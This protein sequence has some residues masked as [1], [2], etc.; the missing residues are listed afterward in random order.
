MGIHPA[1]FRNRAFKESASQKNWALTVFCAHLKSCRH[2]ALLKSGLIQRLPIDSEYAVFFART[3]LLN[4]LQRAAGES[5]QTPLHR[6]QK[7]RPD[8]ESATSRRKSCCPDVG[9]AAS[10]CIFSPRQRIGLHSSGC[11]ST[12][13]IAL[14][15][16]RSN[17]ETF[18]A[19]QFLPQKRVTFSA[20]RATG[21]MVNKAD[22]NTQKPSYLCF[23]PFL[24]VFFGVNT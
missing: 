5:I 23:A 22:D 3:I 8:V 11:I 1:V 12:R 19:I 20:C 24:I 2:L 16:E 7:L 6:L 13:D 15:G 17:H 10:R 14:D 18:L 9:S 21:S 4:Y